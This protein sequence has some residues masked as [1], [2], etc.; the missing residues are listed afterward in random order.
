M[1]ESQIVRSTL[2]RP[3]VHAQWLRDFYSDES[4]ALYDAAFDHIASLLASRDKTPFLDA[5]CGDGTHTIRLARRGY[6][7]VALDFSEHI[8]DRARANLAANGLAHMVTFEQGSLLSLP[9]T[10]GSFDFVLCWGVLMH[11]PEVGKAVAELARVVK[12]NGFL[13]I[14]EN[15]MWSL[16]AVLART[17][18]RVLAACGISSRGGK[19]FASLKMS[20]AGAEYW[21]Q[22]E[23]GP[24]ICREARISWLIAALAGHGFALK[25]RIA[26]E[27]IERHA[28]IRMKSLRHW[29]HQF[30]LAWFKHVRVPQPAEAN[31]LIFQKRDCPP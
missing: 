5:G 25:E 23:S 6:P 2:Q 3:E 30:N 11:I 15:N 4:R 21:R 18:R 19:Q 27:F 24:L 8:L 14:S 22:T 9:L 10:D 17:A 28:E 7:V 12:P 31:L 20:A 16:E 13:I 1:S 29:V 26:G